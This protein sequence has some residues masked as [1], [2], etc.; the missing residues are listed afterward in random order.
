MQMN[1]TIEQ[2][3][4]IPTLQ[5]QISSAEKKKKSQEPYLIRHTLLLWQR[6]WL[7]LRMLQII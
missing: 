1:A 2:P 5:A 3:V 7:K 6:P 4:V